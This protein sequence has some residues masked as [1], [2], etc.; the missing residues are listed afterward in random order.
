METFCISCGSPTKF[1]PP[2][3]SGRFCGISCREDWRW[4]HETKPRIY[5]GLCKTDSSSARRFLSERDGYRCSECGISE[6]MGKPI[7]LDIDHIDGNNKNNL[8]SNWR[9]LCPN[10]HRQ[11][12]TW[13]NSKVN[14][15]LKSDLGD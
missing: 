13:G 3:Y 5:E 7:S 11:T 12:P 6:W 1:N 10:C 2:A 8:P 14:R 4:N 15:K 9:Y